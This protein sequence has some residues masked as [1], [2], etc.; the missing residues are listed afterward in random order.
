MAA[1]T[2]WFGSE[3]LPISGYNA[4]EEMPA[5]AV[6]H[7]NDPDVGIEANLARKPLLDLRLRHRRLTQ[8]ADE[9]TVA[10]MGFVE[11]AL[12]RRAEQLGS[13]V[14]AVELDEDRTRL[15]STTVAHRR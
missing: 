15:L 1:P 14:E 10:R 3:K 5:G 8:A 6:F 4:V 13:T 7:L 2:R 9:G 12:R 11:R